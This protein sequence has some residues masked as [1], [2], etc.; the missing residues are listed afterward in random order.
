MD[1]YASHLPLL[2]YAAAFTTGPI[3]ELGT[4]DYSTPLL[5]QWARHS[6]RPVLSVESDVTWY[7]R[8][9]AVYGMW[10]H[11][12]ELVCPWTTWTPP[13]VTF[14]LAFIDFEP[15]ELR[16]QILAKIGPQCRYIVLHDSEQPGFD[17]SPYAIIQRDDRLPNTVVLKNT[18]L[19][20]E[21]S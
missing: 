5:H 1:A 2:A 11:I 14:G 10:P 17:F 19:V 6:G 7:E 3:L 18:K 21:Y 16:P 12:F 20:S 8:M 9:K 13:N 4:G 15:H